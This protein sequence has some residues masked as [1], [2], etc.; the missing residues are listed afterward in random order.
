MGIKSILSVF[1]MA[2]RSNRKVLIP[3]ITAGFPDKN[4]FWDIVEELSL[5]GADIIEI[6]VPFSDPIADG[7]IIEQTSYE[8]L[9]K[10]VS[11]KW[12]LEELKFHRKSI[13]AEILLMGYSNPFEIYG[14]EKLSNKACETGISGFIVPDLPIEESSSV[15]EIF[16]KNGLAF[17]RL[18]GLNT[19]EIRMKEYAKKTDSFVYFVSVLG[20]TGPR[21]Q[22]SKELIPKLRSAR[23]I[24]NQP[25]V[26]GFG[27]KHPSQFI[28]VVDL[29]DGIVFGSSL[30]SYIKRG[31][32]PKDFMK[33]WADKI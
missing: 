4:R 29:I 9:K 3:Y 30:I 13:K 18:I 31:G 26:I 14:W 17:V 25:I 16:K 24:F 33:R 11:L 7:P 5:N 12:I 19:P 22:F 8:C 23:K 6:G 2:K 20:T 21:D 32:S 1:D 15:E 27:A 10:G 28:N